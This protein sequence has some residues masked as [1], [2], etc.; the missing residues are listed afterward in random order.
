MNI[1]DKIDLKEV[2][3]YYKVNAINW[4]TLKQ[5]SISPEHYLKAIADSKETGT[6]TE[7]QLFGS[8][9]HSLILEPDKAL[10][11]YYTIPSIDR[12]TKEGKQAYQLAVEQNIGK[13]PINEMLGTVAEKIAIECHNNDIFRS[14]WKHKVAVEKEYYWDNS[15]DLPCK[16]KIDML[17]EIKGETCLV[18][19]K[20]T[21]NISKVKWDIKKYDYLGQLTYYAMGL[22]YFNIN[23]KHCYIIFLEK[24]NPYK[25]AVVKIDLEVL[26][27]QIDRINKLFG[28]LEQRTL[29]KNWVSDLKYNFTLDDLK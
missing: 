16:M 17:S 11:E 12:R 4:S 20:T 22:K 28:E 3:D 18:E 8:Y 1:N 10:K 7:S 2:R 29:N 9:V 13:Q 15:H 14:L 25:V 19:L 23:I 21:K 6:K 24:Y 27:L 26:R 5:L